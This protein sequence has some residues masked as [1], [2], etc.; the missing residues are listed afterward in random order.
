MLSD[1][2]FSCASATSHPNRNNGTLN[3]STER[4]SKRLIDLATFRTVDL[5]D[6]S[7]DYRRV[8]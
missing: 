5:F 6:L 7:F 1:A 3:I 8:L 4:L 2:R